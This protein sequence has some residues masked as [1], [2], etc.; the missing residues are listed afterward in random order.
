MKLR[1]EENMLRLRLSNDELTEFAKS[2][3]LTYSLRLGADNSAAQCLTYAL[4]TVPELPSDTALVANKAATLNLVATTNC[5][6]IKLAASAAQNWL[7]SAQ[8]SITAQIDVGTETPLRIIV[9]KDLG[10]QH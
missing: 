6:T 1:L 10:Y 9:E 5:I 8:N 3:H 7:E 4:E 2:G